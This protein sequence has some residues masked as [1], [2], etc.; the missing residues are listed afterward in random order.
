MSLE[1]G[2]A[3]L[4]FYSLQTG[5]LILVGGLLPWIF[6]LH[7]PGGLYHYWRLLL[8]GCLILVFQPGIPEPLPASLALPLVEELVLPTSPLTVAE[9]SQAPSVYPLFGILLVSGIVLRLIWLAVG[10]YRLR[11]LRR[12]TR[13]LDVPPQLQVLTEEVG[14]S[15]R[16][17]L[18]SEVSGPVTFGWV[19]PVIVFPELFAELDEGMQ[20]AVA[21]HELLHVKRQ[22]WFW[23]TL[24]EVV[25][26]VFWFHPGFHWLIDRIQLTREQVVDRESIVLL[27]SRKTYLKSMVE[28]ARWDNPVPPLPAPLFLKECQLSR[29]VRLLLQ[30]REAKMSKMKSAIPLTACFVV[31]AATGWWSM[32]AL[33]LVAP[34][35]IQ[36]QEVEPA[37]EEPVQVGSNVMA[38]KLIHRVDPEY[39]RGLESERP[40]LGHIILSAVV[41]KNGEVQQV[42]V[43]RGDE[44]HPALDSAAMEA[45]RQWRYEPFTLNGKPVPARTTVVVRFTSDGAA[46]QK[47]DDKDIQSQ[48]E[49][50]IAAAERARAAAER[51]RAAAERARA[52]AERAQPVAERARAVAEIAR[53]VAERAQP[54]A[55]RARAA[56]ERARA[57]AERAQ[58]VAERARAVAEI[59]RAV[60]E[61][62]RPVAERA[63]AAAERARTAAE[64]AP[65][66]KE[67]VR[68]E[69]KEP[70]NLK[71]QESGEGIKP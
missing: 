34:P 46:R 68:S 62:A 67:S 5:L 44:D 3:N 39:P 69:T 19:R 4:W 64:R 61:R 27:G 47:V 45:V 31:L 35:S 24:E 65:K 71:S 58:P 42:E 53:A 12:R 13:R 32:A 6:R 18:S 26:T 1:M 10:F 48:I 25:R 17:R 15:A 11:R 63:R 60:A 56:A 70:L 40:P 9:T 59:A 37:L 36:P 2:L 52:A 43:L 22:D 29:R 55:E 16:F 14:V 66:M 23:N 30:L 57:A 49:R 33:P 28:I 51:A 7:E 21:C 50:A 20:R 41:G 54:V 8:A 38:S